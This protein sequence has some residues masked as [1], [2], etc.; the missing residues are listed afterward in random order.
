MNDDEFLSKF[1][2]MELTEE[3]LAGCEHFSCGI[4]GLLGTSRH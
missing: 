1:K 2:F 4:D 3:V